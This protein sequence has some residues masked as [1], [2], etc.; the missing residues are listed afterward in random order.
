M[1]RMMI[2][3]FVRAVK[4]IKDAYA[5]VNEKSKDL[6]ERIMLEC[7]GDELIASYLERCVAMIADGKLEADRLDITEDEKGVVSFCLKSEELIQLGS[8]EVKE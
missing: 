6:H 5:E 1:S 4:E 7:N 3:N 2:D 8:E